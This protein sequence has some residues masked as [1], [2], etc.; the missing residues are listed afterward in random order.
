MFS[1]LLSFQLYNVFN[2]TKIHAYNISCLKCPPANIHIH[3]VS[4]VTLTVKCF[5]KKSF[6]QICKSLYSLKNPRPSK[7]KQN[8]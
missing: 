4:T 7:T 6:N 1:C 3:I 5:T 2:N 8:Q